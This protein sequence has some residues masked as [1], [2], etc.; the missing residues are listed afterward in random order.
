MFWAFNEDKNEVEHKSLKTL[1]EIESFTH[2]RKL[3][4]HVQF[5]VIERL[6]NFLTLCFINIL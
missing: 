4:Y 1:R 6:L 5:L 3:S 2:P